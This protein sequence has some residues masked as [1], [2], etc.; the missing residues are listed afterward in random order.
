[1]HTV[2]LYSEA[3]WSILW[4]ISVMPVTLRKHCNHIVI[5]WVWFSHWIEH[6]LHVCT[7]KNPWNFK[8]PYKETSHYVNG[9]PLI[10][11]VCQM[12]GRRYEYCWANCYDEGSG[13][14]VRMSLAGQ[15]R[16]CQAQLK[17]EGRV[18]AGNTCG[19]YWDDLWNYIN[20][21]H[22]YEGESNENRKTEIKIRN[23]APLSYKLADMLPML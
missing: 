1:M 10:D 23:I 13:Y 19:Q 14:S 18:F 7:W 3:V 6:M 12:V 2:Y 16:W 21:I 20:F 11:L 8:H 5:F 17:W 15:Q 9:D 4:N 22:T